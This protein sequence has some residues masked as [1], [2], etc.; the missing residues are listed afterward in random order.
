MKPTKR[1]YVI[2]DL[3]LGGEYA[4]STDGY[5]P[6][7][8]EYAE[9]V[10]RAGR[11]FRLC[12]HVHK[13]TEFVQSVA[14]VARDKRTDTELVVN[15]D[16]VDFLAEKREVRDPISGNVSLG[17]QPLIEN[18]F[19]AIK[20]FRRMID[21]DK[22]FFAALKDLLL[23]GARLTI[24]L[25]N[26]DVELCYPAM[27]RMLIDELDADGK[28]FSFIYDGEAYQV[29]KVLIEH[30]NRYD[31]WNVVTHDALRRVRSA[32]SRM[33]SLSNDARG[34]EAP[35]GS[36]LVASIMNE[37]K[38]RYPFVDLLKPESEAAIPILL[39]LAPEYRRHIV[40]I[41]ELIARARNHMIGGDGLPL[42]AGDISDLSASFAPTG[43]TLVGAILRSK[44]GEQE[45]PA[46]YAITKVDPSHFQRQQML[47]DIQDGDFRSLW[48]MLKL[49]VARPSD[50]VKTRL[51][52][53][54]A[55]LKGTQGDFSFDRQRESAQYQSVAQ[56]LLSRGFQIVMFGHTHLAKEVLLH[57][58]TYFNTGTWADLLPFPTTILEPR[59]EAG[60]PPPKD[61]NETILAQLGEFV[62]DMATARLSRYLR[63]I[64]TYARIELNDAGEVIT[65]K[66]CEYKGPPGKEP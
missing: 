13:L 41:A 40:A 57:G 9:S 35:A 17:W 22:T 7:G 32:Q 51:P 14:K 52:T 29:G 62:E 10:D 19:E 48:S 1:L 36:Y 25:G 56:R 38:G 39:A 2:S 55:A 31:E 20:I 28:R 33:E 15:G 53:L 27:R 4:K 60:H 66:L 63:F 3:H 42:Q 5:D 46:F 21:R 59:Y 24:I 8:G 16:F 61:V 6:V 26:H 12:T 58:G 11:G 37:I 44:V 30:G 18:Q 43:E 34:F 47:G 50:P 49:S 23:A 45:T 65:S 64:P 54:L